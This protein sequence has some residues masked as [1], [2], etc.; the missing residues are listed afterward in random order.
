MPRLIQDM[1]F[2]W[3]LISPGMECG[4]VKVTGYSFAKVKNNSEW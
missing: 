1:S 2:N 3:N 4:L